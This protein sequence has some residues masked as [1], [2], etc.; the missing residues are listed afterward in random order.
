ME[1][2]DRKAIRNQI[3]YSKYS[4][5]IQLNRYILYSDLDILLKSLET[6]NI[7]VFP[8]YM[9]RGR[10]VFIELRVAGFID[11][12]K[13]KH[14]KLTNSERRLFIRRAKEILASKPGLEE[15]RRISIKANEYVS[16]LG[17]T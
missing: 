8:S 11:R 17:D 10:E 14:V 12:Y 15:N 1:P 2:I 7:I 6:G 16:Q 9:D 5:L 4:D 3:K 13:S